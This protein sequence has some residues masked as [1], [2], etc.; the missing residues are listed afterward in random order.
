MDSPLLSEPNLT[1]RKDRTISMVGAKLS[2]N[3]MLRKDLDGPHRGSLLEQSKLILFDS[4]INLLLIFVPLGVIAKLTRMSHALIFSFNFLGIIPMAKILGF[5]TEEIAARSNQTIGGLLNATFGNA[6]EMIIS[7]IALNKNYTDVVQANL[8]G[9]I[10]SNLLFVLGFCFFLGGFYYKE[11][12]FN[13]TAAQTCSSMMALAVMGLLIPA[14]FKASNPDVELIL[15]LSHG[16]AMVMLCMYIMYLTFQLKTH[17]YLYEDEEDEAEEEEPVLDFPVAISL[18]LFVTVLISVAA[19]FLMGSL[20][21]VASEWGLSRTFIG[22]I[23][24]PIVGNAAEHVTA[25]SVALKNKMNL[26]I[27]VAIGS[28]IQ[29]ALFVTPLLVLIGWMTGVELTLYFHEF[30]TAVLFISVLIVNYMIQDGSSNW[31]EGAML[32]SVYVVVSIG[33]FFLPE[34]SR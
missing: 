34:D 1:T 7:I 18:L 30:E 21:T 8:L 2:A 20:E 14:A 11:Q 12:T 19:E 32:L 27:G 10:L 9:S 24:L 16:T 15:E 5:A 13:I 6:V 33:F 3:L 23:L 4:Y 26:A 25:V 17:K 28:S 31:L 22:L 29:I